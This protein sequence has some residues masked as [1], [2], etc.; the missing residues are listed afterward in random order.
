LEEYNQIPQE[1]FALR[2]QD[3][4]H[5][6]TQLFSRC[7]VVGTKSFFIHDVLELLSQK[8]SMTEFPLNTK[9]LK[10][11]NLKKKERNARKMVQTQRKPKKMRSFESLS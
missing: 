5:F 8:E 7:E 6:S 3:I 11:S 10:K 2:E 9:P 4:E 1:W